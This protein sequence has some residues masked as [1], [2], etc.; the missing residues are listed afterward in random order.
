MRLGFLVEGDSDWGAVPVLTEKL[1]GQEVEPV[2]VPY[3]G[4]YQALRKNFVGYTYSFQYMDVRS[5]IVVVDNDQRPHG[6]RRA[7]LEG[8]IPE[9][10]SVPV[11]IGVAVQMLEAW[12]LACPET[13]E[14][15]FGYPLRLRKEPEDYAHPKSEVVIPYLEK[16]TEYRR[17]N[18]EKARELAQYADVEVIRRKCK[19]FREYDSLLYVLRQE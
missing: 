12:L 1:L 17:L 10:L 9:G 6:E 2:P 18:E 19:S 15:V 4:G 3:R 5:G 16:N 11:I 8:M 14:R 7:R 13:F